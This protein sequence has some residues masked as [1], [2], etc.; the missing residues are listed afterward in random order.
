[1]QPM[2]NGQKDGNKQE[3]MG[4]KTWNHAGNVC[5]PRPGAD[6]WT[7]RHKPSGK[8]IRKVKKSQDLCYHKITEGIRLKGNQ[9]ISI[10]NESYYASVVFY[11]FKLRFIHITFIHIPLKNG[12]FLLLVFW[13]WKGQKSWNQ[14]KGAEIQSHA[15]T[16]RAFVQEH[17]R[18]TSL[19]SSARREDY[20]L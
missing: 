8:N 3:Q 19:L 16:S 12:C 2:N 7:Q 20:F 11:F 10:E 14:Q 1:M 17:N 9:I 15:W 6:E 4:N 5:L 13:C 18:K